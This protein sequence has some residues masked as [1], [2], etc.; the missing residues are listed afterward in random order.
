M[1]LTFILAALGVLLATSTAPP[2]TLRR[3]EL[4][5]IIRDWFRGFTYHSFYTTDASDMDV[6][7]GFDNVWNFYKQGNN[8]ASLS[9]Q[10]FITSCMQSGDLF[11]DFPVE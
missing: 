8:P 3:M 6:F 7:S 10:I 2:A 4:P 9:S 11:M 1:R 5:E